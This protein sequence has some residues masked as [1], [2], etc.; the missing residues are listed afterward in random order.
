MEINVIY[1]NDVMYAPPP[2]KAE[3]W[4]RLQSRCESL[5]YGRPRI[6]GRRASARR[7]PPSGLQEVINGDKRHLCERCHVCA[8]T[9]K[10]GM[11]GQTPISM[12][13]FV[14]RP[15]PDFGSPCER[16]APLPL[17]YKPSSMSSMR[18]RCEAAYTT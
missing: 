7:A 3:C 6:P 9:S 4:V 12:Q 10:S 5:C 8:A 17:G 15:P 18:R 11:L 13:E 2:A 1:A 14:L 16:A